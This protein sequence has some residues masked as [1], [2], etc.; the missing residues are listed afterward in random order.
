MIAGTQKPGFFL[1]LGGMLKLSQ[2][3]GFLDYS[4]PAS[5]TKKKG[6]S[7]ERYTL[8]EVS[9]FAEDAIGCKRKR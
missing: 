1:N 3:P 9:S 2:K 7:L 5:R 8:L 6:V 4:F